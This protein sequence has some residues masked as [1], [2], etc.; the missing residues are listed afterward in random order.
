MLNFVYPV[1]LWLGRL[2]LR[3]FSSL[4]NQLFAVKTYIIA[5]LFVGLAQLIAAV[6]YKFLFAM[7]VGFVTYQ[8]GTMSIDY[9]HDMLS[10]VLGDLPS[11]ALTFLKIARVDEGISIIF[12][13][14]SAR[15]TLMGV[16]AL[17]LRQSKIFY[18]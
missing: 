12:G 9:V 15:L 14:I 11:D 5:T 18:A 8:L 16:T 17:Q 3:F 7:G 6:T 10:G 1:L 2:F 4:R 13:A